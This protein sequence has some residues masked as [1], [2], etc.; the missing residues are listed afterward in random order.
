MAFCGNCG[1]AAAEELRFCTSCG[2]ARTPPQQAEP[3][4]II[5]AATPPVVQP[6]TRPAAQTTD[7]APLQLAPVDPRAPRGPRTK[8]I[9]GGAA[10]AVLAVIGG[11]AAVKL[12]G[13]GSSGSTTLSYNGIADVLAEP[14]TST[15]EKRWSWTIPGDATEG[16]HVAGDD[17][18]VAY[19]EDAG[20]KAT[21]LDADGKER[22]T[23][24]LDGG[25]AIYGV[26]PDAGVF[27]VGPYEEGGTLEA[28]SLEDGS[29]LW[30]KDDAWL[31]G[32]TPE[33]IL[34]HE[35]NVDGDSG[36][37]DGIGLLGTESGDVIWQDTAENWTLEDD[38]IYV[39]DASMLRS[40]DLASGKERWSKQ[41]G[42]S[43]DEDSTLSVM[44][45]PDMVVVSNLYEAVALS[46]DG[47]DE[48]W[49]E[50]IS[51][52]DE[53][54]PY[55]ASTNLVYVSRW[56][57]SESYTDGEAVFYDATG[58][59][60]RLSVDVDD[61]SLTPTGFTHG[62]AAYF[63][64]ANTNTVYDEKL[65][66]VSNMPDGNPTPVAG[67]FYLDDDGDLSYYPLN[68]SSPKWNLV[69]GGSEDYVTVHPVDGGLI[70]S[71]DDTIAR[72]D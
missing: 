6:R 32:I 23:T 33:G 43:L 3:A 19:Y 58:V 31:A 67:G 41:T 39:S 48:L 12:V 8:L 36:S 21:A 55:R 61:Y 69:V 24:T 65:Q 52:D 50:S 20:T 30:T 25:K 45:T 14:V 59:V 11:V 42:V 26:V 28:R 38:T 9:V 18:V 62:G 68:D 47:E 49:R 66:V 2:T 63:L 51:R 15:P 7:Q 1:A 71:D 4:V 13:G 46:H 44:A 64:D 57:D 17:V 34:F 35:A 53:S 72:Y 22:W 16:I 10:L 5:P 29:H 56:A 37:S 60:G 27:V 40:L 54:S 70:I